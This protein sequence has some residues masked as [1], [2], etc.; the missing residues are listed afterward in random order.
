MHSLSTKNSMIVTKHL[1]GGDGP[2]A[3]F[4]LNARDSDLPAELIPNGKLDWTLWW[5]IAGSTTGVG[6]GEG[7]GYLEAGKPRG[8]NSS[9]AV[10]ASYLLKHRNWKR[11][12]SRRRYNSSK[13]T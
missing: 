7:E 5:P 4:L 8:V 2:L 12:P 13:E 10:L 9:L 6:N 11:T 1:Q 3:A